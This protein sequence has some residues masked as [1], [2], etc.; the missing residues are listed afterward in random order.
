[1]PRI[2]PRVVVEMHPEGLLQ[3]LTDAKPEAIHLLA[4]ECKIQKYDGLVR[5]AS[6]MFNMDMFFFSV[7]L[8]MLSVPSELLMNFHRYLSSGKPSSDRLWVHTYFQISC[9]STCTGAGGVV[10]VAC[11]WRTSAPLHISQGLSQGPGKGST[12]ADRALRQA[13]GEQAT[14]QIKAQQH[15]SLHADML[16]TILLVHPGFF[17]HRLACAALGSVCRNSFWQCLLH[18]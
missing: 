10:C 17:A 15:T 1:M 4:K 8:H 6:H 14:E 3:M 5:R 2:V 9:N 13:H 7:L 18:T 12:Q 16:H 11:I